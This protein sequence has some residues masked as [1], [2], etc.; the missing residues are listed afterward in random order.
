MES[1]SELGRA[2]DHLLRWVNRWASGREVF[3]IVETV[4]YIVL[5][6]DIGMDVCLLSSI[7][8]YGG[9]LDLGSG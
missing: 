2:S 8:V 9:L 7:Q 3:D 6:T 5:V 1:R 4:V